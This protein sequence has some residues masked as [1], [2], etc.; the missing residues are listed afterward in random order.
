MTTK[1]QPSRLKSHSGVAR[2]GFGGSNQPP[3][4]IEAV[5]FTAIIKYYNLSLTTRRTINSH[6]LRKTNHVGDAIASMVECILTWIRK[7]YLVV[8]NIARWTILSIVVHVQPVIKLLQKGVR[9]HHRRVILMQKNAEFFWGGGTAPSPEPSPS[10]DGATPLPTPHPPRRLDLNPSHSEIT[11]TL[12]L[13]I[14]IECV[15]DY[16]R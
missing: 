9:V 10:G 4:R 1:N 6:N 13:K 8:C 15:R 16:T 7:Q 11:P 2:G 12:L 3:I 5:F 14:T